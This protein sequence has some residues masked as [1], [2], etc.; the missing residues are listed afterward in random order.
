MNSLKIILQKFRYFSPVWVF[1][2]INILMG[3]WVLYIPYIKDKLDLDDAQLGVALFS[4]AL[5][6]LVMI[7]LISSTNKRLGIGR[8]TI[9]GILL[10]TFASLFPILSESYFWLCGSLFIVGLF[11]GSTD[12]T[13]NALVSEIE[14][15]DEVN[16]MSAAHGFFSL[17]GVIG[18][19]IGSF[20]LIDVIEPATHILLVSVVIALTNLLL[21]KHYY[22]IKEEV[23][24]G[25]EEENSFQLGKYLPLITI[26][27]IAFA[28]MG[29]EGAI[30]NWS[31]L[32]L[33]D[34]LLVN[35][36]Q[37]A[38]YGFILFS[39]TMTL[40]RFF[41]DGIS[42]S[43]GPDKVII[44]GS[45]IAVLAYIGILSDQLYIS[46]AGFGILGL[47]LSV[48]IPELF[49]IAGKAKGI[50]PT[51]SIAFV[52]G[53]G[54]VGFLIGPVVLGFIS[55]AVGLKISFY[56]LLG[57]SVAASLLSIWRKK[58]PSSIQAPNAKSGPV[59]H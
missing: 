43:Y 46:I 7:P 6:I 31:K 4:Y 51:A 41:G 47:G 30:E 32:Y 12:I 52:S 35:S 58:D 18:A 45:L 25:Q 3:T 27:F 24:K 37:V 15:R 33:M 16:F 55:K 23:E 40:G 48:I 17:G 20:L 8:Y 44:G 10:F 19:G 22:N 59:D 26:S 28:I 39:T 9:F 13:M 21:A 56:A 49:R 57:I 36:E 42:A 11:S 34:V 14:R 50:S 53:V 54:F 29:S 38:G 5:G 1:A 2:S